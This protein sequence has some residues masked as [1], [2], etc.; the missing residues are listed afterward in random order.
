MDRGAPHDQPDTHPDVL[1]EDPAVQDLH[2][3]GHALRR[4]STE[5]VEEIVRLT[6]AKGTDVDGVIRSS[7]E[8]VGNS[9]TEAVAMWMA[10]GDPWA[11]SGTAT[12]AWDTFGTLAA[13]KA[14]PLD[15]VTKRC[16][17]WRDVVGVVLRDSATTMEIPADVLATALAMTQKTLDVTL[18]RMC[19]AFEREREHTGEELERRQQELAFMATH[20]QLTG[21]PNKTLIL[22]RAEQMFSRARRRQ[23]PVA[24]L[25]IDIDNFTNIKDTLGDTAGDELVRAV[26]A[27]LEGV[28]RD[29]DALGRVGPDDFVVLAEGLSLAAGPELIAERL[30]EALRAPF[31]LAGE[32]ESELTLTASIGIATG[33]RS[34]AADLLRDADIAMHSA[35]C[36]GS[37]CYVTFESGMQ[38]VMQA[39]LALEMDLRGALQR[40]EFFLVYQPTFDLRRM[41][42]TGV[43]TLLR[44]R[45]PGHGVVAPNDFIPLLEETGLIVQVGN[46]VLQQACMQT[47]IWRGQGYAINVAVNVS[48]RQLDGDQFVHDVK[49]AL[50]LSGLPASALTLEITETTLMR[51][52]EDTAKRLHTLK[53][54]GVRIAI[55]DFGTGYSSLAHLQRFPVNS[56]KIDR[57]FVSN[58]ADN[59]E[60]QTLINTLVQ[61]GQALSIETLAEGIEREHELALLQAQK[62]DSGQGFLF[63]KPLEASDTASFLANWPR[64]GTAVM[65]RNSL[66][67]DSALALLL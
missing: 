37:S 2:R 10:G 46:W 49:G 56:L 34:C 25:L 17:R 7:L 29:A 18:V 66:L 4:R 26:A 28:V 32:G 58:L 8:G 51:N 23:T 45:R 19:A 64:D 14:A 13:H 54:L 63:A 48:G 36:E 59:R 24:A 55:D 60:G 50:A 57:S 61:L 65:N 43:E 6:Q 20:D 52:A 21:L 35:R 5:V 44:W 47:A 15:E 38:D 33:E 1:T 39:R 40:Q 22:D 31:P 12:Q 62:C 42:P 53:N 30:H 3:L 67:A 27:R 11:G 9:A 41:I 16:L